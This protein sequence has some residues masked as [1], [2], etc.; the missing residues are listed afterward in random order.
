MSLVEAVRT[1]VGQ[2]HD[3]DGPQAEDEALVA[4][5]VMLARELDG[6]AAVSRHADRALADAQ[7]RFPDDPALAER[8]ALLRAK[9]AERTALDRLSARVFTALGDLGLTPKV[10]GT[11]VPKPA[12][13][14]VGPLARMRLVR[15]GGA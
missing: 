8:I 15:E 1:S 6:A 2:L 14:P 13:G 7:D 3:G 11:A 12:N 5:L 10:R 4:V 9:L